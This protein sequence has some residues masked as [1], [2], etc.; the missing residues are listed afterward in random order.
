MDNASDF[1]AVKPA[2]TAT[3][4]ADVIRP[5]AS[6]V[7]EGMLVALPYVAADTPVFCS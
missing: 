1:P 4:E 2:T 5:W 3:L 7:I 6:T